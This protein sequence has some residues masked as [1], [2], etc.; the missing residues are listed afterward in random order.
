MLTEF[1]EENTEI[2]VNFAELIAWSLLY[3]LTSKKT[4]CW[5]SVMNC[6]E[7]LMF[8][9]PFKQA[10]NVM[11][12]LIGFWDPN[13]VP[14]WDFYESSFKVNYLAL[15]IND[16]KRVIWEHFLVILENWLTKLKDWE[17]HY[18]WLLPYLMTFLFDCDSD[19]W[20][21]SAD[22]IL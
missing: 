1:I 16:E 11:D 14:I 6:L 2:L 5:V 17:D 13:I 10:Y 21:M 7:V 19:I 18:G 15:L 20:D 8:V 3:P 12:I 4:K 22:I 9:G